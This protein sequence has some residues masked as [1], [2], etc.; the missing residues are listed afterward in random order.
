MEETIIKAYHQITSSHPVI[1]SYPILSQ[2]QNQRPKAVLP[3]SVL[4]PPVSPPPAAARGTS[5][6]GD[7]PGSAPAPSPGA[8]G[9]GR[10][11]E[12]GC[13]MRDMWNHRF[14]AGFSQSS[15]VQVDQQKTNK[16]E[17]R[18]GSLAKLIAGA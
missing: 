6:A 2:N 4:A 13:S 10:G 12:G 9:C 18:I 8:E 3:C 14:S 5:A 16:L 15:Q 11:L 7:L 1:P 17:A